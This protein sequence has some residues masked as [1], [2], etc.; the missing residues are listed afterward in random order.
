MLLLSKIRP[1]CNSYGFIIFFWIYQYSY[2]QEQI[3]HERSDSRKKDTQKAMQMK[4]KAD[5]PCAG[6]V[7]QTGW[8]TT[9]HS[10][11]LYIRKPWCW[12]EHLLKDIWLG[13]QLGRII[14]STDLHKDIHTTKFMGLIIF[15]VVIVKMCII[16]SLNTNEKDFFKD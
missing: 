14:A 6:T 12:N 5:A 3:P 15:S 10:S 13:L 11:D 8:Q 1:I 2:K 4:Q 9:D 7:Q 16:F